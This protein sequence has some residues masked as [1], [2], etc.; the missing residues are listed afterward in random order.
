MSMMESN[1]V[2]PLS[3]VLKALRD[4]IKGRLNK[5]PGTVIKT[6]RNK[7]G[8]KLAVVHQIGVTGIPSYRLLYI[9]LKPEDLLTL[10]LLGG[11]KKEDLENFVKDINTGKL[12]DNFEIYDR[13]NYII[14]CREITY[15]ETYELKKTSE[16]ISEPEYS[17]KN[18][19][20]YLELGWDWK[21]ETIAGST[22]SQEE[23]NE[24]FSQV[25][26]GINSILKTFGIE[27][28]CLDTDIDSEKIK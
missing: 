21:D 18:T 1:G 2:K 19:V 15:A 28:K 22:K 17:A 9:V 3:P 27:L 5:K 6:R 16:L 14:E 20:K 8:T 23:R 13:L 12:Q 25:E 26:K 11:I 24:I 7:E 4:I 10:P